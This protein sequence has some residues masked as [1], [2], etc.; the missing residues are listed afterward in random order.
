MNATHF[1]GTVKCSILSF[2]CFINH[3]ISSLKS[4][5]EILWTL[6]SML[7]ELVW[8][9]DVVMKC[10][11]HFQQIFVFRSFFDQ[12]KMFCDRKIPIF[13]HCSNQLPVQCIEN[14][15]AVHC[16]AKN[17]HI[18]RIV[19]G[20]IFFLSLYSI[21]SVQLRAKIVLKSK[22]HNKMHAEWQELSQRYNVMW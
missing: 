16:S 17:T 10:Y 8:R 15:I 20:R 6:S 4:N 12:E 9:Y 1:D 3:A 2:T 21:D 7:L 13:A 5:S 19:K 22:M 14:G 11:V 18:E